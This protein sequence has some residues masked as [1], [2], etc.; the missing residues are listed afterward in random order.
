MVL[1]SQLESKPQSM[2]TGPPS[3][4]SHALFWNL[5][6]GG[7]S[8][9]LPASFSRGFPQ[10]RVNKKRE[11]GHDCLLFCVQKCLFQNTGQPK[12]ER[13]VGT[14]QHWLPPVPCSLV[15]LRHHWG[16]QTQESQKSVLY[17]VI[18]HVLWNIGT[19]EIKRNVQ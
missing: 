4:Q 6:S 18:V 10:C 11:W 13:W 16:D 17:R 15:N 7:A 1:W 12:A 5:L 8:G 14:P 9:S 3:W 19:R 2:E